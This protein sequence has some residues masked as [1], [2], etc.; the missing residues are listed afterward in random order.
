MDVAACSIVPCKVAEKV[1][2]ARPANLCRRIL[3]PILTSFS[4]SNHV[5]G[6]CFRLLRTSSFAQIA[7][8]EKVNLPIEAGT[9]TINNYAV[10]A[11]D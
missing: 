2:S 6:T 10:D 11:R 3:A 4:L 1:L 9:S 7:K 8:E 5:A